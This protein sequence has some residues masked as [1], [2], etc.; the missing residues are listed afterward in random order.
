M[1]I[2]FTSSSVHEATEGEGTISDPENKE[3]ESEER[4]KDLQLEEREEECGEGEPAWDFENDVQETEKGQE[5]D[6]EQVRNYCY[7]GAA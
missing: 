5:E 6:F 2:C 7:L 1:K 4:Q 3:E